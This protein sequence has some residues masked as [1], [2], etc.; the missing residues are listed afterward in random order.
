[1]KKK[2]EEKS[3]VIKYLP[4]HNPGSSKGQGYKVKLR[5]KQ[6]NIPT[7]N[8]MGVSSVMVDPDIIV[9]LQKEAH[10]G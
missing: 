5:F 10:H 6:N 7:R 2:K 8:G 4:G 3:E 1:M 9:S